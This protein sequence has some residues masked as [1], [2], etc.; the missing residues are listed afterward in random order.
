MQLLVC[1]ARFCEEVIGK[2]TKRN[3]ISIAYSEHHPF[4]FLKQEAIFSQT[5]IQLDLIEQ[6]LAKN[7]WLKHRCAWT[8]MINFI[9]KFCSFRDVEHCQLNISDSAFTTGI[10]FFCISTSTTGIISIIRI[11]TE[12]SPCMQAFTSWI[13]FI[14]CG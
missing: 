2:V 11:H 13:H 6:P 14:F 10:T 8:P 7:A 5:T 4:I 3:D 12:I 1:T 9:Q